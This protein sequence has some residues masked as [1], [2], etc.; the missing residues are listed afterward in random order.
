MGFGKK[1]IEIITENPIQ[2]HE[3]MKQE[4]RERSIELLKVIGKTVIEIISISR[5]K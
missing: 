1:T 5:R 2:V 4:S 3:E